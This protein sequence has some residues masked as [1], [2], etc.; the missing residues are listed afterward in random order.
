M[1]GVMLAF[2]AVLDV[3]PFR[4]CRQVYRN[5]AVI[6]TSPTD[7]GIEEIDAFH[8]LYGLHYLERKPLTKFMDKGGDG[9]QWLKI[10][11]G[12]VK[13]IVSKPSMRFARLG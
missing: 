1:G 3:G 13:R 4:R 2:R 8:P 5:C 11:K 12:K 9:T 7:K 10:D 6:S